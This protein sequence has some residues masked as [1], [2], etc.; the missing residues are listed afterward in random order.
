MKND[1]YTDA[2]LSVC[3][4]MYGFQTIDISVIN[5]FET[6]KIYV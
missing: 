2:V 6:F 3:K 4:V 5:E 1:E